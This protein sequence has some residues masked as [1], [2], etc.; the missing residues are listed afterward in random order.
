MT[1]EVPKEE[2]Y[3]RPERGLFDVD[4]MSDDQI[5]A[6]GRALDREHLRL[7]DEGD[8]SDVSEVTAHLITS[9]GTEI[10]DMTARNPDRGKALLQRL[11]QSD[12]DHDL[13]VAINASIVLGLV[14][15]E[16][17]RDMLLSIDARARSTDVDITPWVL[18]LHDILPP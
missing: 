15:Y 9:L 18:H 7:C 3:R 8:L 2:Q 13:N 17:T 11:A 12:N 4:A 5:V 14:D 1:G 10:G 6:L 16:Y